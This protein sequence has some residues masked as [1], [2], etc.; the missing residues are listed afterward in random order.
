MKKFI[1]T[2]SEIERDTLLSQGYLI[3][4]SDD[5]KHIYIFKNK[6]NLSFSLA[7]GTFTLSD[8]LTF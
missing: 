7:D 4:K 3:L 8:T 2:F 5:T 1:Y 6:E